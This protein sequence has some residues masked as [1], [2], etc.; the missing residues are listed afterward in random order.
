MDIRWLK[1]EEYENAYALIKERAD[2]MEK[3]TGM[4]AGQ[5]ENGELVGIIGVDR[6]LVIEPLV[7]RN[8]HNAKALITWLDGKLD[9]NRYFCFIRDERFQKHVEAE[10]ADNVEGWEGK[11]FVRRR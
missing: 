4:L 9:P 11:L 5:F 7:M 6:P 3:P 10:Y 1:P 8:G 2:W